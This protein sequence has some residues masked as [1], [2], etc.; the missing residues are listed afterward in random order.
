MPLVATELV[1]NAYDHGR[2][3]REIRMLRLPEP[4]SVRAG[5]TVRADIN[6][7]AS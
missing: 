6:C 7:G 3:P 1:T 4:C 2:S 5:K